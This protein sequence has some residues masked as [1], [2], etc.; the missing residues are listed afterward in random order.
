MFV[1]FHPSVYN[2]LMASVY[3][4][5]NPLIDMLCYVDDALLSS[6]D[7]SKGT[8]LLVDE[9]KRNQILK[10]VDGRDIRYLCGGSC[11][12]TMITFKM[13]GVETTLAGGI[14][15]DREGGIYRARLA[16]SGVHDDLAEFSAP[17]GTS[18]ILLTPDR[19]RT[20]NTYLGANR[21][22]DDSDVIIDHLSG[23]ELFYF[24]GYM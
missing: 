6:L 24:T 16:E 5:G 10:A 17:T 23:A 4:I 1:D 11:P 2:P 22:F 3:G 14:G 21:L 8:M 12:N 9:K 19:E 13:L 18:I 20:M 7:L 15:Q